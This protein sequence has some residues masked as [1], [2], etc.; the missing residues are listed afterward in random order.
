MFVG[1]N[2]I[3]DKSTAGW[4]ILVLRRSNDGICVQGPKGLTQFLALQHLAPA[5][6]SE[7]ISPELLPEHHKL[8]E[9]EKSQIQSEVSSQHSRIRRGFLPG[10]YPRK[11][12]LMSRCHCCSSFMA[13]VSSHEGIQAGFIFSQWAHNRHSIQHPGKRLTSH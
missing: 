10:L 1:Q 5:P 8:W 4:P 9:Q 12:F 3:L 6:T 11:M 7:L 2:S 13:P